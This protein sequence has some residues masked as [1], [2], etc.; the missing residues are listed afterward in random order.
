MNP[1][2]EARLEK[3]KRT[4]RGARRVCFL[5]MA[6]FS[7]AAA[8]GGLAS[9]A[10][11]EAV[12]C[13]IANVRQPCS[14]LSAP[15]VAFAFV[16]LLGGLALLLAALH[17]LARLFGNYARGEIFTRASVRELRLLGYVAAA[18]AVF[19]LV[20]FVAGLMLVA[21]GAIESPETLHFELPIGPAVVAAFILLLSWIMDVG[22]EMREENELTV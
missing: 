16:A 6:L 9:L 4:S 3:V 1:R 7:L 22:A 11:P 2:T 14:V 13:A 17:R 20:L 19:Q 15:A 21:G 10:T 5:L 8:V 12:T 18:Y